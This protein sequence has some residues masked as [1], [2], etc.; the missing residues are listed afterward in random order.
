MPA[1]L[2]AAL[3]PYGGPGA[4]F[5]VRVEPDGSAT[6]VAVGNPNVPQD[7]SL[8]L[9][10][11]QPNATTPVSMGLLPSSGRVRLNIPVPSG[12]QLLVSQEPVGG[13]PRPTLPP[14][15]AGTLSG[16]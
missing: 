13:S 2:M 5:L 8:Q 4:T 6:V 10:A 9:W 11:L 7:R 14:V 1:P 15:L 12:T 3:S 16:I